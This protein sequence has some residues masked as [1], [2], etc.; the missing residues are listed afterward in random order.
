MTATEILAELESLGSESYKR[1]MMKNHG[2]K[3]P[4]AGVKIAD[5][6]KIR[7][8]LKVN[9]ALALDLYA[10]GH[11]DAMYLAGLI[12]DDARM[13]RDDLRRWAGAAYGGALPGFTVPWVAAGS[14]HGWEMGLEWIECER[15]TLVLAGWSTLACLARMKPDAELDLE[16]WR[17]LLGRVEATVH[18]VSDLARYGMNGFLIATGCGIAGLTDRVLEAAGKI[19][20]LTADLGNNA[21]QVPDAADFVSKVAARGGIG[22][23]QKSVKC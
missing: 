9:H 7:K 3:E 8:R 6:Q 22:K 4:V 23:K 21:C 1:T 15:P 16:A 10:T 14:L 19:G 2:V 20:P 13:T 18:E 5:L 11:Y 17:A 12:A